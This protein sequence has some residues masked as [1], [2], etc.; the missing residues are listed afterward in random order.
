MSFC[1]LLTNVTVTDRLD[2][3]KEQWQHSEECMCCLE[4]IAMRDYQESVTTGQIH[5][6]TD[7][8]QRDRYVPLCFAG[9]TKTTYIVH[10][11]ESPTI[12][13]P[14][15]FSF[16]PQSTIAINRC[17]LYMLATISKLIGIITSFS[18]L[19]TCTS[20]GFI[21]SHTSGNLSSPT[22]WPVNSPSLYYTMY[23]VWKPKHLKIVK[24]HDFSKTLHFHNFPWMYLCPFDYTAVAVSGKVERL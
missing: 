18:F 24:F 8:G 23:I 9:D 22:L 16:P 5:R 14:I 10:T 7:A 19:S 21:I 4:N 2:S 20:I 6:Q 3:F 17:Y 13:L 11:H 15:S 12:F 1:Q